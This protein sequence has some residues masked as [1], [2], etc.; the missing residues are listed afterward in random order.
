MCVCVC[1]RVRV[2]DSLAVPPW[3]PLSLGRLA[4]SVFKKA[5]GKFTENVL[6]LRLCVTGSNAVQPSAT[7]QRDLP[8]T[9]QHHFSIHAF[10][11]VLRLPSASFVA[12][13][14]S[15]DH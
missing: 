8:G 11:R 1:V 14:L 15:V 10:P 4:L 5:P 2:C 13:R 9:R 3:V 12:G 6:L 7:A